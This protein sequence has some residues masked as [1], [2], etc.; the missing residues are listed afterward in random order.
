MNT[1][2]TRVIK[3]IGNEKGIAK[4]VLVEALEAAMVHAARKKYGIDREIEAKFNEE[5]GEVEIF[6]FRTAIA[7]DA[8][9]ENETQVH[10]ADARKLDPDVQVGDSLGMKLE[11]DQATFGRI[12][13]QTAK[14]VIIQKVRDAERENVYNQYKD[15]KGELVT[16]VVRRFEKGNIIVDLPPTAEAIL[17][18]REQIPGENYR[19]GDRIQAFFLDIRKASR[20]PQIVLSRTHPGLLMKLFEMEVPEI[21]E[22]IVT[23][24][25][26]AREPGA[27]AKIAVKSRDRDVDPV[28]AC[29]GVKGSRVQRVVQELRGEKIDIIPFDEEPARFV[30]NAIQPAQ[31]AKV[32]IDEENRTMEI[33]VPDDQLSLAIGKKGQNVRLA[34]QLTGWKIDITSE[35]KAHERSRRAQESL[36]KI[37]GVDR[38]TAELLYKHG[39][40]SAREVTEVDVDS[41]S[42]IPGFDEAKASQV[43]E[44]ARKVADV[45]ESEARIRIRGKKANADE[46]KAIPENQ[47]RLLDIR[48][49]NP[50]TIK[51]LSAAGFDT[52]EKI[53]AGDVEQLSDLTAIGTKKARQ[54]KHSAELFVQS[55]GVPQEDEEDDRPKSE[56][57]NPEMQIAPGGPVGSTG[58]DHKP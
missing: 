22:G 13:A 52:P 19:V 16:G 31:V 8:E 36:G 32:I 54:L 4:E 11:L 48:G 26:A 39:F 15:R 5:T 33:I 10:L 44:S 25:A 49:L 45:E 46:L 30:C 53:A 58:L 2:L 9:P 43:I 28:G 34:A 7:D 38:Q 35:T 55:G 6:E 40:H 42:R 12:A 14:Q 23:I 29:V 51:Q 24:E 47:H 21:Y 56:Q 27:R 41:L 37:A 18:T 17:P 50:V 20:D 57:T 3:E 1:D